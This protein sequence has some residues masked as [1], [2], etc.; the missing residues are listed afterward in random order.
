MAYVI[1]PTA[2]RAR[3]VTVERI[4]E[5]QRL[6]DA[7]RHA[8]RIAE[9]EGKTVFVWLVSPK[10]RRCVYSVRLAGKRP[11]DLVTLPLMPFAEA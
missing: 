6:R 2:P 7:T 8:R 4:A 5:H 11:S 1:S 10:R 9:E 3:S